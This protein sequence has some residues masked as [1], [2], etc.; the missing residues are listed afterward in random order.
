MTR[1]EI[2]RSHEHI[3]ACLPVVSN[4][5]FLPANPNPIQLPRC[6][7]KHHR[8]VATVPQATVTDAQRGLLQVHA[9]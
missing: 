3:A 6:H 1:A 9:K 4:P 5:S 2:Q 8:Y 7:R